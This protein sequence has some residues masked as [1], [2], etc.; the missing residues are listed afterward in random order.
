MSRIRPL[1]DAEL[2]DLTEVFEPTIKRMGFVP[3]SQRVMAYKPEL[4]KAFAALGKAVNGQTEGSVPASL[5]SMIANASSLAAGCMYCIAHTGSTTSRTGIEDEKIAAIW[6]FETSPLFSE[7]ERSALRFAQAAAAVPNMV[8][9]ADFADLRKHYTDYQIVEIV[10][11]IA[12]FGFLNR[13]N[14]TMATALEEEP[15]EFAERALA[16]KGWSGGKHVKPAASEA[17]E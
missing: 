1:T 12:M 15:I 5:K 4:L 10:G 16:E 13:W 2:G 11:V 17:A 9:D 6:E 14:D 8:T 3:N 7:A